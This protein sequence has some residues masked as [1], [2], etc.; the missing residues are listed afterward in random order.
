MGSK[1]EM[2]T[3][4]GLQFKLL[5]FIFMAFSTC[6][7]LPSLNFPHSEPD[8][9]VY[10]SL[11]ENLIKK[12]EYNLRGTQILKILSPSMYDRELFNHPPLFPILL[13]PFVM[14]EWREGAILVS[15]SGHLLSILGVTLLV[16]YIQLSR[17]RRLHPFSDE[18]WI[19]IL[20]IAMDPMMNFVSRKIWI[21]GPLAGFTTLSI[22]IFY[23]ACMVRYSGFRFF[24]S[25]VFLGLA[26]LM[27]LSAIVI[28][29]VL[30]YLI[31][32]SPHSMNLRIRSIFWSGLPFMILFLPW[33]VVFYRQYSV[34]FPY[35][36]K[37]DAW[38]MDHFPFV[39]AA[40]ER[41]FYYY[42]MKIYLIQPVV[43]I[44]AYLYI[45]RFS[46]ISKVELMMPI[47]WISLYII[48]FTVAGILKMGYQM[49]HLCPMYP[50]IYVMLHSHLARQE[51]GKKLLLLICSL[52][53]VYAGFGGAIYLFDP[54]YDEFLSLLEL[55][56]MKEG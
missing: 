19:P 34:F 6:L 21:D 46:E 30:F 40:V 33:L 17:R 23:R 24:L 9:L 51:E 39:R 15:W 3:D 45:K 16:K 22:A 10:Q 29:P 5:V 42:I 26:S 4:F 55:A 1:S 56:F 28:V 12:G 31:M 41:P 13:I 43:V 25:G 37:P 50:A 20:G 54:R 36:A 11:A 52:L 49:R 14:F 44:C 32:A 53:I 38:T 2:D 47:I 7:K 35:W 27:K 18:V 48:A 8:E